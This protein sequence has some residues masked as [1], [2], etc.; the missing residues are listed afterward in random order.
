MISHL[1]GGN[2]THEEAEQYRREFADVERWDG[3]TVPV[4]VRADRRLRGSPQCRGCG[5]GFLPELVADASDPRPLWFLPSH[6]CRQ[7]CNAK[8][9]AGYRDR[10]MHAWE[11]PNAV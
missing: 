3:K 11:V 6:F 1:N 7:C 10:W 8:A 4:P 5:S 9:A 2:C